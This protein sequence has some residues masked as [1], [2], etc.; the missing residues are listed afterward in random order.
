M[1]HALLRALT[2]VI[3]FTIG[4]AAAAAAD[5]AAI[6]DQVRMVF[7]SN[8]F[9]T[10]KCVDDSIG[11][12]QHAAKAGYN[13]VYLTDCKFARWF[14]TQTVH[15][16]EYDRNVT[17][18]RSA[19]R[20]AGMKCYVSCCDLGPDT[21]SVAPNLAEGSPVIDAPFVVKAGKLEPEQD[22]TL[23]N[24][25]F[26]T[27]AKAN[28]PDGWIIDDPG[29]VG[30]IDNAVHAEGNAS[31][32]L[33]TGN[34]T[35]GHGRLFQTLAVK[36]FHYYHVTAMV[37]TD[38]YFHPNTFMF[39][40]S[41]AKQALAH[42]SWPLKE[43]QDWTRFE[44]AFNSFDNTEVRVMIGSWGA[45][46][47]KLWIDDLH[48]E[49]GGFVN[50]IRR[51]SLPF[52]ITSVD[53]KT[54]YAEGKDYADAK[55]PKLGNTDWPGLYKTWYEQPTVRIPT[56]SRLHEGDHVLASY[57]HAAITY[58]YG[59]LACLNEPTLWPLLKRNLAELHRI[60]QPDGYV[61]PWDEM[62][63]QGWDA[64]CQKSGHTPVETLKD[65]VK[66]CIALVAEEDPGKPMF[67]WNDMFDP[68]HN[69]FKRDEAYALVKGVDP[70]SG[71]WEGLPKDVIILNWNSAPEHRADTLKFF[72]DRG[73]KQVLCGYYD[74][75][76][77]TMTPWLK[78]AAGLPGICGVMYTT[79]S[80]NFSEL[81]K[82]ISVTKGDKR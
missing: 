65:N 43:T 81:E 32:R 28:S 41:G 45:Q 36:P 75:T 14:D 54:T 58:G 3:A 52:T 35:H 38:G 24:G 12:I 30:F 77:D 48:L 1:T 20:D 31:V 16:P 68:S 74:S 22:V 42:D 19:I 63:H 82:F 33:E 6:P 17:K 11:A 8:N 34:S 49:A 39:T 57:S 15:R 55:D 53:G 7:V 80:N 4:A 29:T 60:V 46:R 71:S 21:M 64:S 51:D 72:A 5:S 66:R 78:E 2:L 10:A 25:S 47:G 26:E 69:A 44:I 40:V 73:H 62:R 61:L 59:I 13:A 23:V 56:G 76:S 70:W 37:K 27:A 50:L 67:A 18:I 9:M 79:W